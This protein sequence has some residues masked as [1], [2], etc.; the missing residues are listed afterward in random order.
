MSKRGGDI[1]F[2]GHSVKRLRERLP[3]IRLVSIKGRLKRR[4]GTELRKGIRP[5]HLGCI[6]I[7]ISPT[8]WAVCA[9]SYLGGFEVITII[10]VEDEH[11]P[12]EVQEQLQ[13]V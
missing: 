4:I 10:V 1:H 9:P 12:E 7:E 2:S 3:G 5:N 13:G 11:E 6:E 8:V